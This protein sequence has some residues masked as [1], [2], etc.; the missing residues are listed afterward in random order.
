MRLFVAL[1][2]PVEAVEDLDEFLDVRRDAGNGPRWSSPAQWHVTLAFMGSAPE[3]V[4]EP[5]V[6]AVGVA[7]ARTAPVDLALAGG[8]CFPDVTRARVL[9]AR[10]AG[11]AA[12]EPLARSVRSACATVG[13]APEGGE[14]R[15]HVTLGRFGRPVDGTRW[16]RVLQT[17]AGPSW[18]ATEV[19][20]VASH[21]PRERGH[22]PRH[23]VLA[24]LP[25]GG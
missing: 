7:A 18:T 24:L 5:V 15:A 8:G 22:R 3:R 1:P 10:V 23:E 13:A 6:E 2:P 4:V 21:L 20:V 17:Y 14:F 12:L 9:F 16:V 11:G 25:L 19:A